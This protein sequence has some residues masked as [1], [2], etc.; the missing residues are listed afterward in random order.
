MKIAIT[1]A[2]GFVG[3]Y[4]A[5]ALVAEGHEV[6]LLARGRDR[7][8]EGVRQL[9]HATF[10]P[11]GLDDEA[12]LA[13]ALAGCDAVAHCAGINRELGQ[14]TYRRVHVEGTRH[15]VAAARQAGV[16]KL[17][18]VSFLRARPDCG[19]PY[20]ESK[21]A[22]E[23]LVRASG[24]DYTII[25]AGMI[26]GQGDHM[27]DHLSQWFH[28]A[29]LLPTVGMADKFVRPLAVADM[30]AIMRAAL[31]EGR[32]SR[33]TVAALGPD[34]LTLGDAVR[35]VGR[36]I[37]RRVITFRLPVWLHYAAAWVFERTMVTP[38][39]ALAQARILAEG[40]IEP[41]PAADSLPA[42]LLPTTHFTDDQIRRGVPAPGR[43]GLKDCRCFARFA[44]A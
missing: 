8:D 25:K 38:L 1:G 14:Q 17:V 31:V 37:D 21:W 28:T 20:H 9:P 18:F 5:R 34:E 3:R 19:S 23:E 10:V 40:V 15:V 12:Q 41:L 44:K 7:R 35:Q 11:I 36:A 43:F 6:V 13:S 27:L 2:T 32:L 39:L 42:D 33:Q 26:Y 30:V 4:L 22:A 16:G 24:L 29:P